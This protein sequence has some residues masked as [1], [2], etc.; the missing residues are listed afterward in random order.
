MECYK[1]MAYDKKFKERVLKYLE[2]GHTQEETAKTFRI[3]TTTIKGW[4][5][6]YKET[7]DL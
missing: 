4:K 5:K 1:K 6:Q 3:G 2:E 7:G